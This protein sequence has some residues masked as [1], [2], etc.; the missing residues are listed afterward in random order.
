MKL[1]LKTRWRL[2]LKVWPLIDFVAQTLVLAPAVLLTLIFIS[3]WP[4]TLIVALYGGLY[5]GPWQLADSVI[6][7]VAKQ[8][9]LELRVLH[10][11]GS[12]LY[13]ATF[14]VLFLIFRDQELSDSLGML[15]RILGFCVPTVLAFFYYCITYMTLKRSSSKR[16][17]LCHSF[18]KY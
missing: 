17:F 15:F 13:F 8:P 16:F 4:H 10:L 1:R 7:T 9:F 3:E 14:T 18:T 5:L 12:G 11:I 6:T 2:L